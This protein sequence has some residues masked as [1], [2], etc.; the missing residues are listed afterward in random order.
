MARPDAF[1]D[2]LAKRYAAQP[3]ADEAAY[4]TKLA[5]TRKLFRPDMD[6][7][8]FGC[9]TGSTAITHAPLVNHILATDFSA[10]M[11][12]IARAKAEK[13]GVT[14]VTFEQADITTMPIEP[15]RYDMVM[16]HSI[17]HL[18]SN[19]QAAVDA[20]FARLKP[21]GYFVT[22]T[23]CLGGGAG[24]ILALVAPLGRLFGLLP[25]IKAFSADQLKAMHRKSGFDIVHFWQPKKGAAVFIIAQKPV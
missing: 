14:N 10:R 21:G 11:V 9:G 7:L 8:E 16:G 5:E 22:S 24:L 1:W 15:N 23:A 25:T 2:R 17:L 19:P 18:L 13:A 4:Q 12:E 20:S 6:I 3:V